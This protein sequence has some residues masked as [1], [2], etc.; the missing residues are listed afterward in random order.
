MQTFTFQDGKPPELWANAQQGE[1]IAAVEAPLPW[2]ADD[3]AIKLPAKAVRETLSHRLRP[4]AAIASV[5]KTPQLRLLA[6]RIR[7]RYTQNVVFNYPAC[8]PE[9]RQTIALAEAALDSTISTTLAPAVMAVLVALETNFTHHDMQTLLDDIVLQGGLEYATEMLIALQFIQFAW[10]YVAHIV[11]FIPADEAAE[12]RLTFS[13]FELRLRKHLSLAEEN[14]WH[15]C[16]NRLIAALD[17]MPSCRQPLV[18]V[19]LPEHP[20]IAHRIAARLRAHKRLHSLEWLKMTATDTLTLSQLEKYQRLRLF[21][22]GHQGKILCA[23]V[24]QEQGIQGIDRLAPYA[25]G[26]NCGD[27]LTH[28]NHPKALMHLIRASERSKRSHQRMTKAAKR[29]PHAMLAALA[30]LLAQKKEKRW[31]TMLLTL[32]TAQ[33]SLAAEAMP[34]LSLPAAAALEAC[35]R[36][37][38]PEADYAR[39]DTLPAFYQPALWARP[40]LVNGQALPDDALYNLGAMLQSPQEDGH[41]AGLLRIKAACTADSLAAF[42]WDLFD[43]WQAAGAPSK[44]GWAFSTLGILGNDDTA[45]ALAPLIAAWREASRHKRAMDGLDILAAIGSDVAL[46]QLNDIAMEL[47]LKAL[48][49]RAREQIARIAGIRGLTVA[50]LEDRLAADLDLDDNGSL[51]LDFGPRRFTVSLDETL[52]PVVRDES[53]R[54]L[55][56]LPKPNKSDDATQAAEAVERYRQFKKDV[57]SAAARQIQRL[58]A[59]MCQRRRWTAEQFRRFLVE[60][61]LVGHSTRR[62]V[63]GVYR[64]DNTLQT[65]FRVA[66]DNSYSDAQDHPLSLPKGQIGIPHALEIA[67]EEAAAFRQLFDDYHLLP[68]FRQLDRQSYRLSTDEQNSV[69]LTRWANRSCSGERIAALMKKGWLRGEPQDSGRI[70]WMLKPLG[71]WTL[72]LETESA[73]TL[74]TARDVLRAESKMIGVWLWQGNARDYDRTRHGGEKHPFSRLEAISASELINDIESL[75][76]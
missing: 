69:D 40:R 72:V 29:F 7:Q 74:D 58:E 26:D 5:A 27:V 56:A 3:A 46:R 34:W 10:D 35:Q 73:F 45:R 28:V 21:D 16:A 25:C 43:A 53:G 50:E 11:T 51:T 33:P 57:R 38:S 61:P 75:F 66:E 52:N 4:G 67:Q 2:L 31:R 20:E 1:K 39:A 76:D 54:R 47:K 8:T 44:E 24:L 55:K 63:W 36:Q 62:L 37:L 59:A 14:L 48:P 13:G 32:L 68:P 64:D 65:C 71:P 23:T 19:L 22:D 6:H 17:S 42:A 9:W 49:E 41:E 70:C 12:N 15:R 60:P 18:A 30:E